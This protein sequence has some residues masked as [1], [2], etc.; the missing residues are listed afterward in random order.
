MEVKE[1][2]DWTTGIQRLSVANRIPV[3]GSIEVTHRCNNKC[4]HC[5]NNLPLND[6]EAKRK[7]L[8]CEEHRRILDEISGLGC[9]WLLFTGGEIFARKDFLDIYTYAKQKGFLVT[10]FTNGTLI[11]SE[12]ADYLMQWRP[13]N[14]EITLY[15]RTQKTYERVTGVP[16]SFERCMRGIR[17]LVERKLPLKLKTMAI[18]S[19][20]HELWDMKRFVEDELGLEFKFDAL[21][22]PRCD[23]S[24]RPLDVRLSPEEVV[25]LDLQ[26]PGR[27]DVWR[28]LLKRKRNFSGMGKNDRAIWKCG[29]GL[30][31]FAIDP[32]GMLRMC[33]LFQNDGYDLRKGDFREG[34]E[35]FLYKLRQKKVSKETKCISCAIRDMCG[36][37]PANAELE[38]RDEEAP[39]DFLCQVAHLRA[40]AFE[41]PIPPHGDCEYCKSGSRY[42]EIVQKIKRIV[43]TEC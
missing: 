20:K 5:Y 31:T 9:L 8:T 4:V 13:F 27:A 14:I 34:W 1:Y 15:G 19:N 37:C 39:V 30:N 24:Q 18:A 16:G 2:A 33:M 28:N 40:Y 35:Q 23:C 29:S 10:L 17:L 7:E 22:N 3:G 36:K 25:K 38:C 42:Q 6:Q 26:D 11:T 43:R 12:I 41:I 21:L 32:S